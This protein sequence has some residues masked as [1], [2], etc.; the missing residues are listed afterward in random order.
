MNNTMI[1]V[2]QCVLLIPAIATIGTFWFLVFANIA[3]GVFRIKPTDK[4]VEEMT[5]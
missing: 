5:K 1:I 4:E 3:D 2:I